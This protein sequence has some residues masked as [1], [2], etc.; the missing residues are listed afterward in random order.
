MYRKTN[1]LLNEV[2]IKQSHYTPMKPQGET[3]YSSYS[4]T[5]WALYSGEW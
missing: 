5:N 2:K 4:F 3:M 1:P